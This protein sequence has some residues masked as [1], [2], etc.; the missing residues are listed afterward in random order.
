MIIC[1]YKLKNNNKMKQKIRLLFT[2]FT[3]LIAGGMD[4]WA[5]TVTYQIATANFVTATGT[6]PSS[7]SV[8]FA[9]TYTGTAGQMT[10]GKSTTLTL[11]GYAGYKITGIVLSMKSNTSKGAGTFSA[12]AGTTTIASIAS[13]TTFNKWYNNTD[14]GSSYRDITVA[15]TNS[16]Y[17]IQTGENVVV[18]ITG[19]TN[20]LYIQSYTITYENG[21]T[22]TALYLIPKFGKNKRLE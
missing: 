15:L 8:S 2:I 22:K 19:T 17:I 5:E 10:S 6:T 3:L 1:E 14:Y 18:Q 4:M 12:V 16:D 20:S 13:A 7:S 11:T 9:Q 21:I